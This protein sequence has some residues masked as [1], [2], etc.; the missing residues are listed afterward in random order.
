MFTFL[1]SFSTTPVFFMFLQMRFLSLSYP[2]L[3]NTLFYSCLARNLEHAKMGSFI[4]GALVFD[5]H[6]NTRVYGIGSE[7]AEAIPMAISNQPLDRHRL[8][9]VSGVLRPLRSCM[10]LH[11]QRSQREVGAKLRS[12]FS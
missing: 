10:H 1:P 7:N 12:S 5:T 2:L 11:L 6:H 9:I 4:W 3:F 8:P